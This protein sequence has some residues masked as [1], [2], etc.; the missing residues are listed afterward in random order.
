MGLILSSGTYYSQEGSFNTL[1]PLLKTCPVFLSTAATR[2]RDR[3]LS[4]IPRRRP[5][6]SPKQTDEGMRLSLWLI[7][8]GR[9]FQLSPGNTMLLGRKSGWVLHDD[10][11]FRI[12]SPGRCC[13]PF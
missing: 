10:I 3:W 4:P 13:R 5:K 1:I 7:L 12:D 2:W 11:L 8:E 9:R 6:W